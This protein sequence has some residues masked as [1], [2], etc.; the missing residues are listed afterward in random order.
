[1]SLMPSPKGQQPRTK[2]RKSSEH[3]RDLFALD[4]V[5]AELRYNVNSIVENGE[6]TDN[7]K[8]VNT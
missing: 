4:V 6:R 3:S 2:G 5:H 8:C 7:P 1:M